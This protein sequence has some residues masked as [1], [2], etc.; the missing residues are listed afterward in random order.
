MG[1]IREVAAQF[2]MRRPRRDG[3]RH[4][5]LRLTTGAPLGRTR[6][7]G[8]VAS[9]SVVPA[10]VAALMAVSLV[11]A[12]FAVVCGPGSA[13]FAQA[14]QWVIAPNPQPTGGGGLNGVSCPTVTMCMAVGYHNAGPGT[15]PDGT[16]AE[17]WDGNVWTIQATLNPARFDY[18]LFNSVSCSSATFCMAVGDAY[19]SPDDYQTLSEAWD[20]TSWTIEPTPTTGGHLDGVSCTSP[21]NCIAVGESSAGDV[22][23]QWDG[24]AWTVMTLPVLALADLG[25]ISCTQATSCMAVGIQWATIGCCSYT[26]TLAEYWDGS[27]WATE[28]TPSL[29]KLARYDSFDAVS[30][31]QTSFCVAAGTYDTAGA[32]VQY[33]F[34]AAWNGTTWTPDNTPRIP[35]T[36]GDVLTG[37]TCFSPTSCVATGFTQTPICCAGAT[38][39][40]QWDG[41]SWTVVASPTPADPVF[42]EVE[43]SSCAS[44]TVCAAVGG[45][46]SSAIGGLKDAF[47][48]QT[49][50]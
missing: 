9:W 17:M 3:E 28:R 6:I 16:L 27:T 7:C 10:V 25:G 46:Q 1:D 30:C 43:S 22:A 49:T 42:L 12:L 29:D 15:E 8:S 13:A 2:N 21:T 19:A 26:R 40:D 24:T 47:I 5:S 11:V 4:V 31:T 41:S 20:G 23:E 39:V 32:E 50:D 14:P 38:L 48:M 44:E 37:I 18:G 36:Y 33:A 45:Y 34:S 35:G